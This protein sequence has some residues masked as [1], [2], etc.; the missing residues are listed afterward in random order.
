MKEKSWCGRAKEKG[1]LEA[2]LGDYSGIQA[3]MQGMVLGSF[4][5]HF[6]GGRMVAV[7]LMSDLLPLRRSGSFRLAISPGN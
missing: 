4:C 2:E 3:F 6:F 7:E 5:E 1:I